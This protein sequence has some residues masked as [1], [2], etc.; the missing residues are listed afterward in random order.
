MDDF[1]NFWLNETYCVG[2]S[3]GATVSTHP[4]STGPTKTSATQEFQL[5][6]SQ[7]GGVGTQN[8]KNTS[9]P[10]SSFGPY[11]PL[12]VVIVKR[13]VM[14]DGL[15]ASQRLAAVSENIR[16]LTTHGLEPVVIIF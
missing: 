12:A 5:W 4:S 14:T 9:Q 11:F 3:L 6:R 10:Q 15:Y 13:L 7:G 2:T 8:N 1:I 16:I